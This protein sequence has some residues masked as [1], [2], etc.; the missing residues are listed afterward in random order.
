MPCARCRLARLAPEIFDSAVVSRREAEREDRRQLMAELELIIQKVYGPAATSSPEELH[1]AQTDEWC[2][3]GAE[4]VQISPRMIQEIESLLAERELWM[5]VGA[6]ALARHQTLHPHWRVS[7]GMA[8]R[9][10]DLASK[11]GRLAVGLE[12]RQSQNIQAR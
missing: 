2:R 3:N 10:V 9:L 12:L 1:H 7:L 6:V 5:T 11:L 4:I 8:V